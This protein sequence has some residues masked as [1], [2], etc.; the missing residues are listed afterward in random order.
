MTQTSQR[1]LALDVFRGLTVCLMIIVNTPG[2]G[3]TTFAPLNHAKWDG[4]TPTDLVFPSF[5][6]AVGNAMSF[7]MNKW[8]TLD[9]AKVLWKILKRTLII[10]LLGYLMYWFPFVRWNDQQELVFAP[11]SNTRVFGVLQRIALCYGIGALL[12]YYFKTK[13]AV[14]IGVAFLVLYWMLLY[15][16]GAPGDELSLG[17]NAVLRLDQWL[18]GDNHLYHGEGVAFDPEGLLS[19]LPAV[20][21]VIGGY[22]AGKYIQQKG[23]SYEG[24]A[25]LMLAGAILL[26]GAYCWN[27]GFPINKKL[28]SSSFVLHT[29]GLDCIILGIIIYITQFLKQTSWAY[30]FEVFG[31]NPLFIYLLSEVVAILLYFIRVDENTSLFNWIYE[32]SFM[33]LG[34]YVGSLGFAL[35]FMLFCW[36]VGYLLDKRKIYVRV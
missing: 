22:A 6:F 5:L 27:L 34:P 13:T 9:Q 29:V 16:F 8:R 28:W 1:F 12:V 2:D 18:I 3:S 19:T 33:H 17:G 4:F 24:L 11:F 30:F 26:F 31:R 36:L 35:S 23:N 14:W 32:N 20:A 10:F 21:N 7:V 15:F 25:K